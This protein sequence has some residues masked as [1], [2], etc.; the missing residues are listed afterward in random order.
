M[1]A[2]FMCLQ[3]LIGAPTANPLTTMRSESLLILIL[4]CF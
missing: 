2:F 1:R 4:I 3:G